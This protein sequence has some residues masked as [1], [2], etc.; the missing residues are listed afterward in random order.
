MSE[1][2]II[3][4][5]VLAQVSDSHWFYLGLTQAPKS[6]DVD[7]MI[8]VA[9]LNSRPSLVSTDNLA[10]L[11]FGENDNKGKIFYASHSK[12]D[13]LCRL[14]LLENTS[15]NWELF[16]AKDG[17]LAVI[18]E[19]N[20]PP[21]VSS[22]SNS[23][24]AGV[25]WEVDN[26]QSRG[27]FN[28]SN[29]LGS[30][31]IDSGLGDR[32]RFEVISAKI[33]YETQYLALLND[34][35]DK[36][37][38]LLFDASAPTSVRLMIDAEKIQQNDLE[39]FLLLN[40][41]LPLSALRRSMTFIQAQPCSQL[42]S[43]SRW[44]PVSLANGLYAVE[45]PIGR[46]R[47]SRNSVTGRRNPHEVLDR[48]RKDTL[49]TPPN[50]FIKRALES[51]LSLASRVRNNSDLY[52]KRISS[53]AGELEIELRNQL[54]SGLMKSIRSLTRIPFENQVLQRREGYSQIF[55]AWIA[56]G[57]ALSVRDL[58]N[59]GLLSPSAENR[60]VPDLY[61]YWLFFF[62]AD[63]IEGLSGAS[64]ILKEYVRELNPNGKVSIALTYKDTPR[65]IVRCKIGGE[66]RYL[67]LYY[68]R[69]FKKGSGYT[70]YS[71]S[72]RPDYTVECF[73][74]LSGE[75]FLHSRKVAASFGEITYIHFDAKFR[76]HNLDL[77]KAGDNDDEQDF[78]GKDEIAKPEDIYK[79]H[80]YNE[81]IR[82]TAASIIL[83]PGDRSNGSGL[84]NSYP[85]YNEL[86]PGVG[87]LSIPPGDPEARDKGL[88]IIRD[89]LMASFS[90][91]PSSDS[92]YSKFR[93]W[94]SAEI[95]P[96]AERDEGGE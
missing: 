47:W 96:P 8:S 5:Y 75:D 31:W 87:A 54:A 33:G 17:K 11:L 58:R 68:N 43:E 61:E 64:E 41:S 30:G 14:R 73:R 79:M 35:T 24:R 76:I 50:R 6:Y 83:F 22:L 60:Q 4:N 7:A 69:T 21:V 18:K 71:L 15:Y 25:R 3:S 19:G 53:E 74:A 57:S 45:D 90:L 49:D 26:R 38:A 42:E 89:F 48:K 16:E 23:S 52:G 37:I 44:L 65:L 36:S 84:N 59:G 51:F 82:G 28:F 34:L 86:I 32:L 55:R 67:G 88:G 12:A 40:S 46:I 81:A 77:S 95:N 70:S 85:K 20:L 93:V 72:L 9:S 39:A 56:S 92:A 27:Q 63:A 1:E 80:T 10:P 29:F 2:P 94:E 78:S 91:S 13:F 62:L 66:A